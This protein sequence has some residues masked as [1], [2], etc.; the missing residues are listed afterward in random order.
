MFKIKDEPD[1]GLYNELI[2]RNSG[3]TN[4]KPDD[5]EIIYRS[6][7]NDDVN[8]YHR[9]NVAEPE[10]DVK[11]KLEYIE[12]DLC[13]QSECLDEEFVKERNAYELRE[14]L[15]E[16]NNATESIEFDIS[17]TQPHEAHHQLTENLEKGEGNIDKYIISKQSDDHSNVCCGND[18]FVGPFIGD[19]K[20]VIGED[21]QGTTDP[22]SNMLKIDNLIVYKGVQ[23]DKPFKCDDC[24]RLFRLKANLGAHMK[25]HKKVFSTATD[26]KPPKGKANED[27]LRRRKTRHSKYTIPKEYLKRLQYEQEMVQCD[28]C[29]EKMQRRNLKRHK[30]IHR[31]E[32]TKIECHICK[33]PFLQ[34]VTLRIHMVTHLEKST[35]EKFQCTICKKQFLQLNG[36]AYH[37]D[38]H[39]KRQMVQCSICSKKF[40]NECGLK[41]H[42]I[43]HA[44]K[45][46]RERIKCKLCNKTFLQSN[47]LAYH[48]NMVH[49]NGR[50]SE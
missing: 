25:V 22:C 43:T 3:K 23:D 30:K 13:Q 44:D 41:S 8:Y 5:Y 2:H 4:Q 48:M 11:P 17:G 26:A 16:S 34:K 35:R 29:P 24:H 6:E 10:V 37:M 38:T 1:W 47:G 39:K 19:K 14:N 27:K 9:L 12:M 40:L 21:K 36:L 32:K 49:K 28:F 42:M 15:V 50:G 7:T 31:K 46:T 20:L 45:S 33:K 18:E